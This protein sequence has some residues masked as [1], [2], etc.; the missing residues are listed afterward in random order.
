MAVNGK[1][2]LELNKSDGSLPISA[3]ALERIQ[4][5]TGK[6]LTRQQAFDLFYGGRQVSYREMAL[7]GYRPAYRRRMHRGEKSWYF[8]IEV[9]GEE[10][11]AV[12]GEER[13]TGK[14]IWVTTYG[15]NAFTRI[16][17]SWCRARA[18][19]YLPAQ[20]NPMETVEKA[21]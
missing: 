17:L 13:I 6:G 20:L 19:A 7:L 18:A 11:I 15:P 8:R 4:R 1:K 2:F 21:S 3:H 5:Y 16:V 9:A 14:L 12:I 10:L